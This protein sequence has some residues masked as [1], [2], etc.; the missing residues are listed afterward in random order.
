MN[1][2]PILRR[3][4]INF[5]CGASRDIAFHLS[6]RIREGLVVRNCQLGGCWGEEELDLNFNPFLEG[7][8][9]EVSI[10]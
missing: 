9:F 6:P 8:Y 10:Y 4:W 2:L 7:Q 1:I 5:V 3:F